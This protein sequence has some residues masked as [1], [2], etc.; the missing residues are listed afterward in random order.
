[1]NLPHYS[2][3]T[4]NDFTDYKF[5]SEGPKGRITKIVRFTKTQGFSNVYNLGFGDE[6]NGEVGF[7]D[8]TITNNAD[9]DLVLSTVANTV[10]DFT[11]HHPS[12][13]VYARGSTASRTR[14]Y[15]IGIS[16]LFDEINVYFKIYGLIGDN[17]HNF[18]RNINY[19]AFLVKRK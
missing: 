5:F 1:M 9:T 17:W 18:Q 16:G 14:L 10:I 2:Y 11:D 7:D 3:L 8:L 19:D 6:I 13:Y 15:Q 4:S 12:V